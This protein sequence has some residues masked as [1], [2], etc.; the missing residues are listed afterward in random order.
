MVGVVL[1]VLPNLGAGFVELCLEMDLDVERTINALEQRLPP[2]LVG[3]DRGARDL[4]AARASQLEAVDAAHGRAKTGAPG[5]AEAEAGRA[6]SALDGF[7]RT[8]AEREGGM[9]VAAAREGVDGGRSRRRD[10]DDAEMR[11]RCASSP[12]ARTTTSTATTLTTPTR[13]L[14]SR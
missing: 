3:C 10:A 14:T 11:R 2:T 7:P 4:A 12:C 9:T 5:G 13:A 6:Q 8:G 1:G